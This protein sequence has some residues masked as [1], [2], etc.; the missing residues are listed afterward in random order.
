MVVKPTKY[1][2]KQYPVSTNVHITIEYQDR[3]LSLVKLQIQSLYNKGN[4]TSNVSIEDPSSRRIYKL[5]FMIVN[6]ERFVLPSRDNYNCICFLWF[7]FRD[8]SL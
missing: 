5:T 1:I 8:E 6:S 4:Q 2:Y 7:Q 3:F